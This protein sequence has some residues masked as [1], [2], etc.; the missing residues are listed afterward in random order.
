MLGIEVESYT[1]QNKIYDGFCIGNVISSVKHPNADKLSLC[2]V[3]IGE[4]ELQI[5]CGAPNVTQGQKVVVGK[6]GAVVPSAGFK[7]EKRK[8]RD[9]YSEGMICS[10]YE[11]NLGS[12]QEGI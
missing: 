5:I 12:D 11:L 6:I 3:N 4:Q 1:D 8:I 7:L 2:K 9:Y 10:Q